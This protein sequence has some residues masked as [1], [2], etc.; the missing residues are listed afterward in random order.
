MGK[1]D[2][3][4]RKSGHVANAIKSSDPSDEDEKGRIIMYTSLSAL[5]NSLIDYAGLFPPAN[6]SLDD[7]ITEYANYKK[8]EDSWMLGP[9]VLPVSLLKQVKTHLGFF[10]KDFPLHLSI[11]GRKSSS[12]TECTKQFQEDINHISAFVNQY[13]RE[14][15]IDMI[16]VPLPPGVPSLEVLENIESM[17]TR[18][19]QKVFCEVPLQGEWEIQV[20]KTLDVI[21]NHNSRNEGS[22]GIK[23]RTGGILAEMFPSTKQLALI[24]AASRDRNLSMKFTAG[25]HHPIRMYREEVSTQM[26]GFLNVFMAGMLA[27]TQKLSVKEIDEILSDED[28]NNFSFTER[29]LAW[30]NVS[31]SSQDIEKV[32]NT[33]LLS[34]GSCSFEEPKDELMKLKKQQGAFF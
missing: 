3:T 34:F 22:I 27:D 11:V 1:A 16:E 15:I 23:V 2:S 6:L 14:I 32:R 20:P 18:V 24:M 5:Q 9:F 12:E 8:S 28:A 10:S 30:R 17:A 21:M 31:I 7:A 33:S 25:L 29:S 4:T 26:H 19:V 13:R